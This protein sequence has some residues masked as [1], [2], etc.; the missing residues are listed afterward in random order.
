MLTRLTINPIIAIKIASENI[1][2]TGFIS[3]EADSMIMA[4]PVTPKKIE[5]VYAARILIFSVPC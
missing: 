4:N 5:L 1:I 3:F 2:F